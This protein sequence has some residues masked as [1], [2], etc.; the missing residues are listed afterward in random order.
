MTLLKNVFDY[1]LRK[2][3]Y[4]SPYFNIDYLLYGLGLCVHRDY[5]GR[6]IATELL[7][8][9]EPL[10]RA[11]KLTVTADLFSVIGSQK[12]ASS[13]GFKNF[14]TTS[15]AEIKEI[16]PQMD[17]SRANSPNCTSLYLKID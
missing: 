4:F 17:F 14:G 15:Y 5:R 13:A 8:A 16:F 1:I 2:S 10:L 7:K 6:G 11:L 3:D 12:A 9:R